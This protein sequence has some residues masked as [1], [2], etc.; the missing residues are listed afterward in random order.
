MLLKYLPLCLIISSKM[1]VAQYTISGKITV[2]SQSIGDARV[3]LFNSDTTYFIEERSD[4]FGMFYFSN[5]SA[6]AYKIGVAKSNY[7]YKESNIIINETIQNFI[8]ELEPETEKGKWDVIVKSPEPLGG[9]D[10]RS[11]DA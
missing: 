10:L 6:G 8:F 1:L 7:N 2:S 9:T 11:T 3:T 5:V 4:D